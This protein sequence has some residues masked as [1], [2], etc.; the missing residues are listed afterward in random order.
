MVT[1]TRANSQP[2]PPNQI[3]LKCPLCSEQFHLHYTENE[4]HRVNTLIKSAQKALRED[5]KFHH[6]NNLVDLQWN[7][8]RP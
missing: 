3:A 7:P 6:K 1:L 2:L 5:H 8:L 4:W